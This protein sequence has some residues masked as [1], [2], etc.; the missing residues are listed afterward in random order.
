MRTWLKTVLIGAAVLG[1]VPAAAAQDVVPL[2]VELRLDAG[3]PVQDTDES[4]DAAV[5][6]GVRASL[7]LARTFAIYAGYSR[8][9]FDLDDDFGEGEVERGGFELGGRLGLGY[10]YA[11]AMPYVLLG[12]LFHDDDTGLEAGLGADYPV[13]WNLSVTPE[14][15]YR[16]IDDIDYLTLGMGARFHF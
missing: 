5:G 15:R 14:V 9:E 6:F 16:T 13:S 3:I 7:D 2:A 12:A 1:A 4:L 8:F 11:S 10:G